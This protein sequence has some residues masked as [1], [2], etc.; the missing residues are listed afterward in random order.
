MKEKD[1]N[2]L[3]YCW[4]TNFSYKCKEDYPLC[5]DVL[6]IFEQILVACFARI[7]KKDSGEEQKI[8]TNGTSVPGMEKAHSLVNTSTTEGLIAKGLKH[9]FEQLD[10]YIK[11][12]KKFDGID[13][14]FY[15]SKR[16]SQR[17]NGERIAEAQ[18]NCLEDE[19]E[20]QSEGDSETNNEPI[21]TGNQEESKE[22]QDFNEDEEVFSGGSSEDSSGSPSESDESDS[23][24][25][26][27]EDSSIRHRS[28][29][30]ESEHNSIRSL[31][32]VNENDNGN[33]DIIKN[34]IKQK[35]DQEIEKLKKFYED[36]FI[37]RFLRLIETFTSIATN[38][39]EIKQMVFN[40]AT[41]KELTILVDLLVYGP[42]RH[43]YSVLKIFSNLF[44]IRLPGH[45]FDE[46]VK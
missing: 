2:P 43:G 34:T 31:Q 11:L 20:I 14:E 40:V 22:T 5:Q 24:N 37:M 33:E 16:N 25:S 15:V 46:S 26:G 30:R 27:S 12:I 32:Y 8:K 17:K 19:L 10:R 45:I 3:K 28:I 21:Q 6:E 44:K 41:S 1:K 29:H 18:G 4:G 35:E 23:D 39:K 42:P 38:K 7:I 36:K 9:I 13:W